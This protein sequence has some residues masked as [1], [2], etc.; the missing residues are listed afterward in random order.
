MSHNFR[1]FKGSFIY[2]PKLGKLPKSNPH[3][4]FDLSQYIP[5]SLIPNEWEKPI[6]I[7]NAY[8]D[9]ILDKNGCIP[10]GTKLYHGS[11]KS[12]LKFTTNKITFFGID[13]LISLWY[14]L[15]M[16]FDKIQRLEEYHE[17]VRK[18]YSSKNSRTHKSSHTHKNS[19]SINK[20]QK[21]I[22]GTLYEFITTKP[23]RV[24]NKIIEL[25]NNPKNN[26]NC[27][28]ENV[29][30]HPQIIYHGDP[31]SPPPYDL[32]VEVTLDVSKYRDSMKLNKKYSVNPMILYINRFKEF[33]EFNPVDA[34][35]DIE[36]TNF[37]KNNSIAFV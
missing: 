32:G 3:S 4:I 28:K 10:A 11:T 21:K 6:K 18:Q 27:Q 24:T 26:G 30:I 5:K 37:A 15:E 8:I 16:R 31:D 7:T 19:S 22:Y 2:P 13:V 36:M 25:S 34:I 29:C 17:H 14:I 9:T 20:I 12:D 23:I 35:E 33:S 1:S